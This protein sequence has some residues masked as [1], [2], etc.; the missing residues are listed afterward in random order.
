M[1]IY[2]GNQQLSVYP[3][4][5]ELPASLA[6]GVVVLYDGEL[7]RGLNAGESSL[8]AGTP[9]PLKGYKEYAARLFW[10]E[11]NQRIEPKFVLKN[12]LGGEVVWGESAE[13]V[14]SL[15]IVGSFCVLPYPVQQSQAF[16]PGNSSAF[17]I[18]DGGFIATGNVHLGFNNDPSVP[19]GFSPEIHIDIYDSDNDPAP[20]LINYWTDF[21]FQFFL[22]PPPPSV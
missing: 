1:G 12:T 15:G 18:H 2:L 8:A 21:G 22:Y 17:S 19:Q 6:P 10:S 4:V 7:Y 16:F 20:S 9:W 3:V 5:D 11:E 14:T 13:G